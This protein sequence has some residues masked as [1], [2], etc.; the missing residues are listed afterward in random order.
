MIILFL[1]TYYIQKKIFRICS[2]WMFIN[3]KKLNNVS[4]YKV[5]TDTFFKEKKLNKMNSGYTQSTL[6]E[7]LC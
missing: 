2:I 1:F 5:I 6:E 3:D 7:I 4:S